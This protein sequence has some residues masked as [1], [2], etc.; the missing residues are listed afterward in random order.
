MSESNSAHKID[1][2]GP[3]AAREGPLSRFIRENPRGALLIG[4]L[5]IAGLTLLAYLPAMRAGFIWDDDYYVS[6]NTLLRDWQGLQRI[7]FDI[8]PD[9]TIYPL[10]QYYPL[11]HTSFWLEYRLWGLNPA[12]YHTVNIFLHIV[13]ALLIWLLLKKLDVPGAFLAAALFALHPLNVESVAWIAERKNTLSLLFFLSSLYVYLRYAGIIAPAVRPTSGGGGSSEKM[14][15]FSLPSDPQRLY[16]LAAVLFACALFSKTVT[17]SMPAVALLIIIWKRGKIALREFLPMLPMFAAGAAMGLLTAYME[18]YRVGTVTRPEV[19]TYGATPLADFG[20]RCIIAGQVVWF[21]LYKLLLPVKLSFNYPRWS[22]QPGN[23]LY[24]LYPL[25]ILAIVLSLA[26]FRKKIGGGALLAALIFLGTLFP[27]MGFVDVWP[28]QFSFVA[29]HFVYLPGIAI[30]AVFSAILVRKLTLE[31]VA[32]IAA[33]VLVVYCAL[34][35]AEAR[36]HTNLAT[37]WK[38]TLERTGQK[39]WMAANNYGVYLRNQGDL[40]SAEKWFNYVIRIKPD[41]PESRLNLAQIETMRGVAAELELKD[42]FERHAASTRAATTNPQAVTQ[43]TFKG[44]SPTTADTQ[45][46][47]RYYDQAEKYYREAI[48]LQPNFVGAHY[49]LAEL[50]MARGREQQAIAEYEKCIEI[51]P[52]HIAARFQLAEAATRAGRFDDAI[53]HHLKIAELDPTSA[54]AYDNLGTALLRAGKVTEGLS[55]WQSAM[56]LAPNDWQMT[57]RFGA[58][59]ASSGQYKLSTFFFLESLKVKRAPETLTSYGVV[60]ARVGYKE[61]AKTLFEQALEIS[62][63]FAKARENLEALLS[64]RLGPATTQSST[65]P[66]T[67]SQPAIE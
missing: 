17:N 43:V 52:R 51:E 46:P 67:T 22:V 30:F 20:G 65:L 49:G 26:V 29:N 18:K 45:E 55:A 16:T 11:T 60:A 28:M 59:L 21:Y 61:Q 15:L 2:A 4:A 40:D 50:L 37:L 56:Q 66:T 12:G 44:R 36:V 47:G 9:P 64:G 54:T 42:Y 14:E 34:S 6:E 63:N 57:G 27:A 31:G 7:W 53:D 38:T 41:H 62:P 8:I 19:W 32:G 23:P 58:M 48:A 39:S 5:L 3:S 33:A 24:Y 1:Y 35:F 10:P 25:S 13:N